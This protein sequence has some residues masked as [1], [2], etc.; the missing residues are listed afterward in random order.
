[1]QNNKSKNIKRL[2]YPLIIQ[3]LI[4]LTYF[5]LILTIFI[6]SI[7]FLSNT[8]NITLSD[9]Q[10]INSDLNGY[11]N[12]TDYSMI[13]D[14]LKFISPINSD[15]QDISSMSS[16]TNTIIDNVT[17]NLTPNNSNL[18]EEETLQS[19][20]SSAI[21]QQ[22]PQISIMNST[23]KPGLAAKLK[24][25]LEESDFIV[26]NTG[27]IK[28]TRNTSI[29]YYNQ[30][31]DINSKYLREIQEIV[32]EDYTFLMSPLESGDLSKIEI[33]IGNE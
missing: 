31:I 4:V 29:I 2:D 21:S 17:N 23:S 26:I 32:S 20:T 25:K 15:N 14:K 7:K 18:N 3:T 22:R 16:T 5:F 12:L 24:T 27:N 11:L 33:I 9:A 1:M 10:E 6:Y 19:A 13:S 8:I 28:P 30:S